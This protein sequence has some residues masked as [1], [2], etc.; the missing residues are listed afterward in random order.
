MT[1]VYLLDRALK[2]SVVGMKLYMAWYG[3]PVIIFTQSL[4]LRRII[5]TLIE[6]NM[7]LHDQERRH[8]HQDKARF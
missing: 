8:F 7:Y 1:A 2:Y 3:I 6:G 4:L 5:F